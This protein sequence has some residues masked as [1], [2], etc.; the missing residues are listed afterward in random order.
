MNKTGRRLARF[1]SWDSKSRRSTN[2]DMPISNLVSSY[3]L[4]GIYLGAPG[5]I[6]SASCNLPRQP[7]FRAPVP[8]RLEAFPAHMSEAQASVDR[9]NFNLTNYST[10]ALMSSCHERN[11]QGLATPK[12]R[13]RADNE[14]RE[15]LRKWGDK[16][17]RC[18]LIDRKS[19]ARV[20]LCNAEGPLD[21]INSL[22]R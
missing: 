18:Y 12:E 16:G 11:L 15:K 9:I 5:T 21:F 19:S 3:L 7:R 14:Y 20:R 17:N 22:R 8:G 6:S 2:R 1:R 13:S 10:K 4:G